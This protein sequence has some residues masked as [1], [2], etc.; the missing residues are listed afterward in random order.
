M[1]YFLDFLLSGGTVYQNLMKYI[2]EDS[3]PYSH[4][5]PI[6]STQD[7]PHDGATIRL[8]ISLLL[9]GELKQVLIEGA[10]KKSIRSYVDA[11]SGVCEV[12][13]HVSV[14]RLL[15]KDG[16]EIAALSKDFGTIPLSATS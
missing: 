3:P 5:F 13:C 9:E 14:D 1:K 11:E 10:M 6:A 8:P 2:P 15:H 12:S 16:R 4:W 7:I